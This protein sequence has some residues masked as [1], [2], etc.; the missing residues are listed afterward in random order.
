MSAS[1]VPSRALDNYDVSTRIFP[2][3]KAF[4]LFTRRSNPRPIHGF[5]L[6]AQPSV[7]LADMA[8]TAEPWAL[9]TES[10]ISPV[11]C[12][13]NHPPDCVDD[14]AIPHGGASSELTACSLLQVSLL[15]SR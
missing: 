8:P 9:L 4:S 14:V 11:R 6:S 10:S 12:G 15:V 13:G 7:G 1:K 3:Q 5:R 2:G